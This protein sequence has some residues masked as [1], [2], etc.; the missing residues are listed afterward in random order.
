MISVTFNKICQYRIRIF[1][2]ILLVFQLKCNDARYSKQRL[3]LAYVR[4]GNELWMNIRIGGGVNNDCKGDDNTNNNHSSD[5]VNTLNNDNNQ[6]Q[7]T[8]TN[9]NQQ[10]RQQQWR[11]R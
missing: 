1:Q 5:D 2:A 10:Q 6:Q 11:R 3:G 7:P 9:N 4:E 8:T